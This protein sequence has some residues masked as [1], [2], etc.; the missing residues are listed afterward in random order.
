M[1]VKTRLSGENTTS[2]WVLLSRTFIWFYLRTRE[3]GK[4]GLSGFLGRK[5]DEAGTKA[6]IS[7]VHTGMA[8]LIVGFH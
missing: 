8:G 5:G 6:C 1:L 7:A 2:T 4:R 3:A